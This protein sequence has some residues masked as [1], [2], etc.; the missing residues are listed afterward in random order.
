MRFVIGIFIAFIVAGVAHDL[1]VR[2]PL[3]MCLQL[4]LMGLLSLAFWALVARLSHDKPA[5]RSR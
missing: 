2:L 1:G 3:T 4:G 5:H